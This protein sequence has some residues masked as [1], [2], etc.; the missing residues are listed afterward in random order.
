MNIDSHQHF[1]KYNPRDYAWITEDMQAIR[2][3]FL[4]ADLR[5]TLQENDV[6][7]T[8]AVQA[9][10]NE[11]ETA[12]LLSLADSSPF[13][14]GVVGW[15]DLCDPHLGDR[16]RQ[17]V[18]SPKL[19]GIRHIVQD[20]P[21]NQFMLR[22]DFMR[23]IGLLE[24]FNLT[25]DILIYPQHLGAAAQLVQ[26]FPRQ[27]FVLDH[28]AK[29]HINDQTIEPWQADL[30]HL[31]KF[32]NVYC[33][34]S[35]MVTEADWERWKP[36]SFTPYLDIVFDAFGPDRLMMGSD[37]PVCL[38]A[39]GSYTEVI[40]IVRHYLRQSDDQAIMKVMGRTCATFYGL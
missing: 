33:K 8:V 2:R 31:A 28:L 5:A 15:V 16:L 17:Y 18:S 6:A 4:P 36:E 32:P 34:I 25:Y 22:D 38:L 19:V 27:K 7:G 12:W 26:R 11:E 30:R 35:G 23:G 13:I 14:L 39:A 24:Q 9:R 20:E 37:W 3:D 40:N 10:Q 1:W 29:P 21:D